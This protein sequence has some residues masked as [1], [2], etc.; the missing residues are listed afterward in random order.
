MALRCLSYLKEAYALLFS[1]IKVH[2]VF[3]P[4]LFCSFDKSFT[5]GELEVGIHHVHGTLS[6]VVLIWPALL[7]LGAFKQRQYIIIAPAFIAET[8][9]MVKIFA[10][11]ACVNHSVHR[12]RAA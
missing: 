4:S 8:R 6:A 1:T 9:P 11:A 7:T 2:G 3:E 12:A 5:G 10:V